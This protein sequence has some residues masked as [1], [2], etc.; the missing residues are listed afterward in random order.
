MNYSKLKLLIA[1]KKITRNEMVKLLDLSKTGYD[2]KLVNETLTVRE[3]EILSHYF[4]VPINYFF[5]DFVPLSKDSKVKYG[6]CAECIEKE[7]Q[8]KLLNTQ[9]A[10][11]DKEI[12]RLNIELE[13]M[14][15]GEREKV[16]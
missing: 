1:N 5:D 14:H 6:S 7:G 9:L 12:L 13:R 3:L 10:E 8:I 11:K 2:K 16:G 4:N 15:P